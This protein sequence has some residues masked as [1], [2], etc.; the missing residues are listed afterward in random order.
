VS[1][2]VRKNNFFSDDSSSLTSSNESVTYLNGRVS[3]SRDRKVK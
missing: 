2:S 3:H 1:V